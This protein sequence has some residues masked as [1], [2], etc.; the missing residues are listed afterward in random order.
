VVIELACEGQRQAI[1]TLC[2]ALQRQ[3][4]LLIR[5]NPQAAA[6]LIQK[7]VDWNK[8]VLDLVAFANQ[9]LGHSDDH[10][11]T[12]ALATQQALRETEERLAQARAAATKKDQTPP[13]G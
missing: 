11:A 3:A 1:T 5:D 4:S 13:S 8:S 10:A 7:L 12:S 6:A 2:N 9:M